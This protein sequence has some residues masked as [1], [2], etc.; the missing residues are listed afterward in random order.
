VLVAIVAGAGGGVGGGG[1]SSIRGVPEKIAQSLC[2]TI[3]NRTS[4][5]H[6]IFSKMCRK[7]FF[8]Q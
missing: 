3:L 6:A 5:S 8:T 7:K 1:D 4:Q 2:T